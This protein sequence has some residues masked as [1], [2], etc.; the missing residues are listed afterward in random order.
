MEKYT[1]QFTGKRT[2]PKSESIKVGV[3]GSGNLEVMIT[4][5]DSD[6]VAFEVSTN[7]KGYKNTWDAVIERFFDDYSIGGIKLTINDAGATPPVVSLR[8]RQAVETYQHGYK[9]GNDYLE[10]DARQRIY[11]MVDEDTFK[12][13]LLND[14]GNSLNLPLL[15]MQTES[16]DGLVIGRAKL[17]GKDIAIAAQQ[18]DFIGGAVG[19]IHGAK[20]NGLFKYAAKHQLDGVVLLVDSGGVRLQEANVGEIEISEIIRS[21][22]ETRSAGVKTIGVIC[23][24]NGA[25]GG[26][27]IISGSLDTL[28]VNQVAR[29]GVSGAEVIQA[30]K[31]VEAFDAGDRP[32]MW[33]VYG[34]RTRY[35]QGTAKQYVSNK[36]Q[37]I[38]KAIAKTLSSSNKETALTLENLQKENKMLRQLTKQTKS[39]QEMGEWLEKSEK[40]SNIDVF[41]MTD[42]AFVKYCKVNKLGEYSG[43]K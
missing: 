34:G 2:L 14:D 38:Q 29:I 13:F 24:N 9:T 26:M 5:I 27:G 39:T 28:I 37:D 15:D 12:E 20:L 4:A 3:A 43:K 23:G 8:L 35:M 21:I 7:V 32:L 1:Y 25:Y 6:Q 11:S 40:D 42:K 41:G 30:V 19:E 16:D 36:V 10:L 17:E 18:K 22:L 33:R 31:G